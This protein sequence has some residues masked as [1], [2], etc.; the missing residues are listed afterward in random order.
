[1]DSKKFAQDAAAQAQQASIEMETEYFQDYMQR[2]GR[3]DMFSA[4]AIAGLAEMTTIVDAVQH[5]GL[6]D[7]MHMYERALICKAFHAGCQ[8]GQ[9]MKDTK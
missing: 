7:V 8:A 5:M 4:I 9:L 6:E 3:D 1:M 2:S